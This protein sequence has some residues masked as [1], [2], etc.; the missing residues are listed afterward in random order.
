MKKKNSKLILVVVVLL[1]IFAVMLYFYLRSENNNSNAGAGNI[2]EV[3]VGTGNIEKAITGSGEILSSLVEKLELNTYR[4]FKEMLVEQNQFV[5]KGEPILKYTNGTY[6]YAPYDLVVKSFSVPEKDAACRSMH[7]IEVVDTI[8]LMVTL[9]IDESELS[10]VQVG[11]DVYITVNNDTEKTFTGKVSKINE[12]GTY[13]ANGSKFT[14]TIS[15]ENDGSVKVGM[16]ASCK[17][18]IDKV[19]NV[20]IVPVAAVQKQGTQKYVVVVN[21]DGITK[22]VPV[23]TGLSNGTYVEIKSGLTIR[24]KYSNGSNKQ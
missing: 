6:L 9:D 10:Q 7:Y 1:V 21:S 20:I 24:R 5:E 14:T 2:Q 4:Y 19:E 8:N 18:T 22:N 13:A 15:F 17:I 16:S 11:Q 23:E 12:L 3:T